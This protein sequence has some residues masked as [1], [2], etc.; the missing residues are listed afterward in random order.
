[1]VSWPVGLFMATLLFP[2]ETGF[3]LGDFLLSPQRILLIWA[4]LW[5]GTKVRQFTLPDFLMLGHAG[6]AALSLIVAHGL[7]QGSKSGGIYIIESIGAY[8]LARVYVK[9]ARTFRGYVK[10]LVMVIIMSILFTIPESI[11]HRPILRNLFTAVLGGPRAEAAEVRHGLARAY[12]PFAHPILYGV[13]CASGFG[14][15]WYVLGRDRVW[16]MG[17]IGRICCICLGVIASV[18]SGAVLCAAVQGALVGWESLTRRIHHRWFWLITGIGTMMLTIQCLSNRGV[19]GLVIAYGTFDPW[20]GDWRQFEWQYGS[21]EVWRHP[22]FG[23]G[24]ND[25]IR[26][27][28]LIHSSIDNFWLCTAMRY[29]IPG[30][31]LLIGALVAIIV[32]LAKASVAS[33][34]QSRFR[35]GYLTSIVAIAI[36]GGTVHLWGIAFTWFCFLLGSGGWMTETFGNSK[37]SNIANRMWRP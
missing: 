10:I 25:W 14:L 3:K 31:A 24:F 19:V 1:M 27:D 32:R 37:S 12:G 26:P 23:I 9:D 16:H 2:P 11:L 22:V 6:W 35:L 13:F 20:N 17:R 18:S 15:S 29:G 33:D 36:A 30:V 5:C 8:W 7:G 34:V 21:A 4:L 28:W